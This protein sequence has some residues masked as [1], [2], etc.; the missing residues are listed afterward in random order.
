MFQAN[1]VT[2]IEHESAIASKRTWRKSVRTEMHKPHVTVIIIEHVLGGEM[3]HAS[4]R[5]KMRRMG[6]ASG[7]MQVEK[8]S[9]VY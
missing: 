8:C 2:S 7:E 6:E 1:T 9:E 4:R 5:K 3:Q